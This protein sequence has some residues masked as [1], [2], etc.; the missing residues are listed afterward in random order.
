[1]TDKF[2]VDQQTL[3]GQPH[4]PHIN[5]GAAPAALD[6]VLF[7]LTLVYLAHF[8]SIYC[9]LPGL[10]SQN[11]VLPIAARPEDISGTWL[12]KMFPQPEVGMEVL[13]LGGMFVA[14][15]QLAFPNA[16]LR[17]GAGGVAVY[18]S[19]WAAWH[20]LVVAGGRFTAYQM[21]VLML[22]AAPLCVLAASWK[23]PQACTFG[24][25][26][27]F[28]R[29]Y[30][31]GG[32]VKLLSCD[33]SWRNLSALHWHF[34]SQPL[35]NP[36]ANAAHLW[37]PDAIGTFSTLS[38]L[39]IEIAVAF[40]FVAPQASIR[41]V[42]FA[43]QAFLQAGIMLTGNFGPFNFATLIIGLCLF[44]ADDLPL[45]PGVSSEMTWKRPAA[46][47]TQFHLN[48]LAPAASVMACAC[49]VFASVWT[50]HNTFAACS[51]TWGASTLVGLSVIVSVLGLLGSAPSWIDIAVSLIFMAGSIWHL[52]HGLGVT[53][54]VPRALFAPF[55]FG[56]ASYGL[57]AIMSGVGGRPT[58]V[59]EALRDASSPWVT[60]PFKYQVMDTG[61]V[62]PL[63]FPHFPRLDWT[64]WFVP[65]GGSDKDLGGW[66]GH[67]LRGISSGDSDILDLLDRPKL[68]R[69]FPNGPPEALRLS[70]MTYKAC[71][72]GLA[73]GD[74]WT[75][76]P[77][78]VGEESAWNAVA[79]IDD[80]A[81]PLVIN[82]KDALKSFPAFGQRPWPETPLLRSLA[83]EN[84]EIFVW[85]WLLGAEALRRTTHT[86]S[87]TSGTDG[88]SAKR[89]SEGASEN[90]GE[91]GVETLEKEAASSA[92]GA[93]DSQL[94]VMLLL[95]CTPH[96]C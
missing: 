72:P 48:D 90:S 30:L 39:I 83:K 67:F 43:L 59:L 13:A 74:W 95:A 42:A 23:F 16:L 19:L 47:Q 69:L 5:Q 14:A 54:P 79:P 9:Q 49:A 32:A 57:F 89:Q 37:L 7:G 75:R 55:D 65:L 3:D 25:R 64:Y 18:A 82:A 60:V 40:L 63:C 11:G 86:M 62:P 68:E 66:L 12:L 46:A 10:F 77:A 45:A 33:E 80:L 92:I 15:S 50:W 41:H 81:A 26:W 94:V 21:D 87:S 8:A 34:Q 85:V 96:D 31:G 24:F 29:L 27:L 2:G 73:G 91:G 93:Q 1:V 76:Y 4:E 61:S 36:I 70:P 38:A 17:T 35:P 71:W 20:D 88:S 58:A 44:D 22:D 51:G 78:R 28:L 6:W 56:A 53:L 52:A 84:H